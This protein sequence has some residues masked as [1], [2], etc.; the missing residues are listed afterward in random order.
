MDDFF[1]SVDL[2]LNHVQ[3]IIRGMYAVAKS[4]D[5]HQTE[6]VLIRQFYEACREDVSGL[7]D[8]EDVI[9]RDFDKDE[10][11]EI[12][13]TP[14][15]RRTFLKSCY[16]LAFADGEF[17]EKEGA[18]LAK[19]ADDLGVDEAMQAAVREEVQDYLLR[20]ISRIQNV[21]ALMEVAK[22]LTS[23]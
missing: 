23:H 11:A 19:L 18:V 5:V 20:Q 17:S 7:A 21:D 9:A 2:G 10:A 4:D 14:E 8:F 22:E 12:L 13:S 15:L 1:S 6:L 3:V 16:L